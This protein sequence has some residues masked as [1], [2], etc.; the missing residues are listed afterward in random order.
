MLDKA[1]K[2]FFGSKQARDIKRLQP[3]VN[4]IN[5]VYEQLGEVPDEELKN[6]TSEFRR[7][8]GV[9]PRLTRVGDQVILFERGEQVLSTHPDIEKAILTGTR[10][11]AHPGA[12][13]AWVKL[14][15]GAGAT[16]DLANQIRGGMGRLGEGYAPRYIFFTDDFPSSVDD[17][18]KTRYDYHFLTL[19]TEQ[20]APEEEGWREVSWPKLAEETKREESVY[21]IEDVLPEAF[22]TVKEVCRRFLGEKWTA[23]G[24]EIEWE[25]VPYDVQLMGAA[26]LAKGNIAEMAT[27]EGKTLA[28]IMPLYLHALT[29]KG[30]HLVTVNNYLSKRDAEWNAPLF[31]FLGMTVGCLDKTEPHTPERRAQYQCDITYGTVNEFGFDYLRDNMVRQKSQLVQAYHQF[32]IIDEVDSV[33]IDEARTPLIISG[34]VDR[35]STLEH[36]QKILPQVEEL[37][38]KQNAVVARLA[39]EAEELLES[40]D[41]DNLWEAGFKMYQA[42]KGSPKHRRYMKLR[43]EPSNMRLQEK[44]ELELMQ[45]KKIGGSNRMKEIEDELYFLVDDRS[46]QIELTDRGREELSPENPD[47]FTLSDIVDDFAQIEQDEELSEEER[48]QKKKEARAAYDSKAQELHAIS[49]LLNAYV[50][51]IRDVDYVLEENKVVIVDENTGRKMPGR[52]WS[53]GLHQAVEAKE[54]VKIEA[55]TQTLAQITIQNYFRMYDR[56]S[57]MTGTA[58]TEAAEFH[59]TYS[60]DVIVIPTNKKVIRRDLDDLIYLT[61]REKYAAV[62]SEVERLNNMDLPILVGTTSVQDSEKLSKMFAARKLKHSVLNAK[63]HLHE[64]MIIQEAGKPGAIT[65]ATNMAGRGTDIKLGEGVAETRVDPETEEEWPGGLQIVGTERHEARRIDR[66]LRG[67]SGRQGDPGTSRFYVSL[68]DDLMRRFGSDRISA[69]LEKLGMEEGEAIENRLVTNSITKAQKKV[70]MMHQEYRRRTLKFDDVLNGQ[71]LQIYSLRR[72]ILVEEDVRPVILGVFE[73]AIDAEFRL[74]YG[75]K[76]NMGDADIAGWLDWVESSIATESLAEMKEG[77]WPD[78]EELHETVM[79][80]IA[81]AYDEKMHQLED[82]A[83]PFCRMIGLQT[84]DSNWQDHLLAIDDLREGIFLR[85]YAQK[86][87]LIEFT[88]D[89]TMMFD[90]F[91]LTINKNIF[92]TFFRAQPMSEEEA[93]RRQRVRETVAQKAAVPSAVHGPAGQGGPQPQAPEESKPR[94]PKKGLSTYRR[95]RPKV[96]RNDPCPCGSGK[97]YKDCCGHPQNRERV[98]HT[99]GDPEDKE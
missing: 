61:K 13:T 55:E 62:L 92:T 78:Y 19:A 43:Q 24:I 66:Q 52:R 53:D 6:K 18:G 44:I 68:E 81:S 32:C 57:G 31:N 39:R 33:L 4:E 48:E 59:S 12:I 86:D 74:I 80:H 72:D 30:S 37:V 64:A 26:A 23:G 93:R 96:G 2:F 84:I 25:A 67:R 9:S 3:I 83:V 22:A 21:T 91:M 85:S 77:S 5:E 69:W 63:N 40:G 42:F 8:L 41:E 95:D 50:I 98:Q 79:E 75:E 54:G 20:H 17:Y 71:R 36:Y 45:K 35:S 70:E 82:I 14:K 60:M 11:D 28:A 49:Q 1:V 38:N 47:Y 73:D 51:K 7:L 99:V 15:E 88:R 29:G 58:E 76:S 89:A 90:E 65:I 56:L 97:K 87:P 27:G 10:R 16:E 46:R 34:P 94:R